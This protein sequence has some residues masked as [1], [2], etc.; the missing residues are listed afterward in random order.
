MRFL[1]VTGL[2][3]AGKSNAV[4]MLE[5]MGYYCVDNMPPSFIS[6]FAELCHNSSGKLDRVALVCDIRGGAMF[7]EL[8]ENLK[9]LKEKHYDYE[10]LFFDADDETLINR[11]KETRRKHPLASDERLPEAIAKERNF[12]ADIKDSA[13]YI[14]D[15][16]SMSLIKLKDEIVKIFSENGR[17]VE[18]F[19][20]VISFGFKHGMPL[21]ADLV[22]DVRFLPNPFYVPELKKMSGLDSPVFDYV[23]SFPQSKEFEERLFE[24]IDFLI[25]YYAEEGKKQVTIAIGCT[26]GRH[27]SVTF[28]QL[29]T[30]HLEENGHRVYPEHR[31]ILL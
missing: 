31:D 16:S 10:V 24:M 11:F 4:N 9:E 14:I 22:F 7:S 6:K 2:S 26:G 20:N 28:G 27:R 12:L 18:M 1:I 13:T 5:D 29:L 3:G 17:D 30:K 8:A 15:T 19:I 21:D 23:M 25:P